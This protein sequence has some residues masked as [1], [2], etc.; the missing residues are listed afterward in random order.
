MS[1]VPENRS[2][3]RFTN[4]QGS[5][6]L[7]MVRKNAPLANPETLPTDL[8]ALEV[9]ARRD[10]EPAASAI[11][12]PLMMEQEDYYTPPQ[13]ARILKLSHQRITQILQSGEMEGK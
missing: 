5:N 10:E 4:G 13:A 8:G 3:G 11:I 12:L 9:D 6:D 1:L 2:N 7:A